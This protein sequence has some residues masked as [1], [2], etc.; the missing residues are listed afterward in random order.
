MKRFDKVFDIVLM[1]C[2]AL[3]FLQGCTKYDT[4]PSIAGDMSG[5]DSVVIR[6]K[7][8]WIN[9]DGAVG[10]V[11]KEVMPGR[12]ASLLPHS[13]YSWLGYSDRR[14]LTPE[15]AQEEDPVTW[16]T[17]LTGVIPGKHQIVG[18][19]YMPDINLDVN[20]PGQKVVYYP[21]LIYRLTDANPEVKSLCVTP[22][23]K[24]NLN[25]LNNATRTITS[26]NDEDTK[27][28]ILEYWRKE[29]YTLTL[30]SFRGMLDA[31]KQGGFSVENSAYTAALKTIDGYI[32][33][34]VDSIQ[35]RKNYANEDWLV[36]ISSNHGGD[37]SGNYAGTSDE[38][39]STFC[40]FYF[41]H[42]KEQ[43]MKGE[44]MQGMWFYK[45]AVKGIAY[46][47]LTHYYDYNATRPLTVEVIMR[48]D[49]INDGTYT[50]GGSWSQLLGKDNTNTGWGIYRQ[51]TE[52]TLRYND[53][54]A[55]QKA[56]SG[57]F[58]DAFWHSYMVGVEVF[59]GQNALYTIFY[60][61]IAKTIKGN[62]DYDDIK[63]DTSN[64]IVGGNS[65]MQPV[66]YI[67]EIRLWGKMLSDVVAA[68]NASLLNIDASHSDYEHLIGYW[69]LNNPEAVVNDTIIEN[70]IPGKPALH[71]NEKPKF[72]KFT[73]T[74]AKYRK[75]GNLIFENTMIAPQIL[76]W[77]KTDVPSIIDGI[78]FLDLY[79]LE[80]EWR[81]SDET[82]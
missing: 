69:K 34:L 52:T 47:T 32:G 27:N 21:N 82:E 71:F 67:S 20:N 8:L 5:D 31:G 76:Y 57:T 72:Y 40:I 77:L 42:Y 30:A 56:Q 38:E 64:F 12:I 78:K 59:K 9:I 68:E 73:N 45:N 63:A 53:V 62:I 6:R 19:T 16:S 44:F 22:W 58:N 46:D 1:G 79:K 2:V 14:T 26:K 37:K 36:V 70:E 24:L 74:L 39:R 50:N 55:T 75:S 4:P 49:P 61:D 48:L 18:N 25:M 43:E 35:G 13:K 66:Y 11:V 60:D 23:Q 65:A 15:N 54:G 17:M 41:P 81:E 51:R 33:E 3:F 7:V 29:D 80:E 28:S 10:N